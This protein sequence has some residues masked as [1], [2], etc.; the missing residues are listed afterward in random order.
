MLRASQNAFGA[1]VLSCKAC[2]TERGSNR[3]HVSAKRSNR[4]AV[5]GEQ[6]GHLAV[7]LGH[8]LSWQL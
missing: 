4:L 8:N 6:V 1:P 7:L 3:Q 5:L 2:R